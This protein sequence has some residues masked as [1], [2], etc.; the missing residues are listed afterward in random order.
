MSCIVCP[1]INMHMWSHHTTDTAMHM[2]AT[3]QSAHLVLMAL[4]IAGTYCHL[5]FFD[6]FS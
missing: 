6:S 2:T 1:A 4:F 5:V 3:Q